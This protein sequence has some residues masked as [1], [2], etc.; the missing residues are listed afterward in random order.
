MKTR[1]GVILLQRAQARAG[2]VVRLAVAAA[3]LVRLTR[4]SAGGGRGVRG[5]GRGQQG[6]ARVQKTRHGRWSN[7]VVDGRRTWFQG[8]VDKE[9]GEQ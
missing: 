6:H 9:V 5:S 8:T 1:N 3:G 2:A 7:A 4:Q